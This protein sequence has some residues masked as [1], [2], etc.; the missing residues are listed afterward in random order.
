MKTQRL[1]GPESGVLKYDILT[2]LSVAGLAGTPGFCT[3]LMRLIA[4]V[5][6][7]YNWREDEFTV[8]QRDMARM[9][10]V[11]ERTVKRQI[12][13]LIDTE[14]VV[15]KRPGVRGRVGAYRLNQGGIV[16][17]SKPSWHLVG[18]DF[19]R[20]M[21]ERYLDEDI[22]VVRLSSYNGQSPGQNQALTGGLDTEWSRVK[23]RLSQVDKA[24]FDAW[25]ARLI[26]VA[27]AGGCLRLKCSSSFIQR[28]IETHL[29]AQ[30]R[31]AAEA[32]FGKLVKIQFE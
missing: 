15:C 3:T 31:D 23:A 11:D 26:F 2:A 9:W 16:R 29:I 30:L 25:F 7:R 4:L 27:C 12:K 10:S 5:T 13:R 8:G 18:P 1:V 19:E 32:E 28:Y 22:K 24:Q 21:Q 20:R 6:A 17:L 14:L